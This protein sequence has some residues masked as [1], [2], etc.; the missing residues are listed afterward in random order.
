MKIIKSIRFASTTIKTLE[1][2]PKED[3]GMMYQSN[4]FY[5]P[6]LLRQDQLKVFIKYEF[7]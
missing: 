6:F 5:Y 3:L 2:K 4:R 1:L 7:A